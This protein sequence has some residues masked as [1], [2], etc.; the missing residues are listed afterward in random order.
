M[1]FLANCAED[2]KFAYVVEYMRVTKVYKAK[3]EYEFCRKVVDEQIQFVRRLVSTGG[4]VHNIDLWRKLGELEEKIES[5]WKVTRFLWLTDVRKGQKQK[6]ADLGEKTKWKTIRGD[7]APEMMGDG[8][9]VRTT[10]EGTQRKW[11]VAE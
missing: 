5:V 2:V 8:R 3:K 11:E 9:M 1:D 4:S 7:E 10:G 6:Y